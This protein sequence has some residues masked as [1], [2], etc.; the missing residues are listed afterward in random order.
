MHCNYEKSERKKSV[1]WFFLERSDL[2]KRE[3]W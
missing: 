3:G 1:K 2:W